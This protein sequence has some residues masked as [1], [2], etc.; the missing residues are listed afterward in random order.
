MLVFGEG[1]KV[2]HSAAEKLRCGRK[3]APPGGGGGDAA[4]D[5]EAGNSRALGCRTPDSGVLNRISR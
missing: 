4:S 2:A 5:I 1:P 3:P